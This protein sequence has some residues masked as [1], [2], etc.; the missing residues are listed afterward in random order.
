MSISP[1]RI[2]RY[3]QPS[4]SSGRKSCISSELTSTTSPGVKR[5]LLQPQTVKI[6]A[7]GHHHIGDQRLADVEP[8]ERHFVADRGA[9]EGADRLVVALAPRAPRRRNI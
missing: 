6:I 8:G 2:E 1:W 5:P 3:T 4:M 9:R 7:P